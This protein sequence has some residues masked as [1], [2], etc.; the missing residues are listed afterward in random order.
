L[1]HALKN[2]PSTPSPFYAALLMDGDKMG[3]LLADNPNNVGAV[4]SALNTFSAKV[5]EIINNNNGVCIYAGGDDVLGLLPLEDALPAAVELSKIYKDSFSRF[6]NITNREQAT[7]SGA[8]IY[9]HHHTPLQSVIQ[10]AQNTLKDI[11]KEQTGR[12]S[13][14]IKVWKASGHNISWSAPWEVVTH[15]KPTVFDQL[16][17]DFY[18]EDKQFTNTFFYNLRRRFEFLAQEDSAS[19]DWDYAQQLLE[20]EY[21][22]SGASKEEDKEKRASLAK[23]NINL[24]LKICRRSWRENNQMKKWQGKLTLDGALLVK[25]LATKGVE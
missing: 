25:F 23:G 9:A 15:L 3:R 13:L 18:K 17:A 1:A 8:I 10:E 11:A 21:I 16:I 12:D 14:A 20:A 2:F 7:L 24:L 5:P 19:I 6:D 4:S 22:K